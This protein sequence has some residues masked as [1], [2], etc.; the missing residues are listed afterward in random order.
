MTKPEKIILLILDG[1]GIAPAWGGNAIEMAE[2]PSFDNLWRKYP[3]T[4]LKAAE[5]AVGLPHHEIGN[6]EVGHL[7]IGCGQIVR[8]NL[9]GITKT[10]EDG[11]FFENKTLVGAFDHVQKNNSNL[12]LLGL[13]SDGGIHSHNSHLY[14]L[15]KIAAEKKI[16]NVYIH[17]ITDGRDT[18]PMKALTYLE[19]LNKVI[20]EYG[21]GKIV[22][23]MGR[24][25]AMDRDKHWDRIEKAYDVLVKGLGPKFNS[26][27][28]AVSD[29]YRQNK[30]DEFVE[31]AVIEDESKPFEPIRPRD[32]VILFNFRA[33]RV[34]QITSALTDQ[35]FKHFPTENLENI[36]FATFAFLEEY[37]GSEK[38]KIVF[39]LKEKNYPL[40]QVLSENNLKQLHIAETEKYAH[41]TYFFN[42]GLEKPFPGEE[43][44][45]VPSPKVQTFDLAP[46][47]SA[48]E[49]TQKLMQ[50][51]DNYDF[52]VCNFANP[53]MVG[54]S[55]NIKA[56]I[57][58]CETVDF[59]L[60]KIVKEFL[61][62]E[63]VL[64]IT[65]DHGNAEQMINPESGEP[66]TEHTTNPVPFILCTKN[67]SLNQKLRLANGEDLILSDIAPTILDIW[68][69]EKPKEMTG[70]SLLVKE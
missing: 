9:P 48:K 49:I 57:K 61:S 52:I 46:E 60:G 25:W 10:I 47:M 2:T 62:E 66:Y 13:I 7:N 1:W 26:P 3:R 30:N 50:I 55:G 18:N 53:D 37:I 27:E 16:K 38:V 15:L 23:I 6:S 42:G 5:E 43:R 24:Y 64:L 29:S 67:E 34:R 39:H 36:Y 44:I 4:V 70:K 28:K 22:S 65:G 19:E 59:C 41:V 14:A 12:H 40:A 8:Q 45:L 58:A 51:G 56:T 69:L 35:S 63:V 33:D 54:H 68:G 20:A 31:P 11:T 32:S 21:V 17:A